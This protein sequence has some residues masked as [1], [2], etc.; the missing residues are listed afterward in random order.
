M[1]LKAMIVRVD[2]WTKRFSTVSALLA[3][4]FAI[5]LS[6]L[7]FGPSRVAVLFVACWI[8]EAMWIWFRG[9]E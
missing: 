9:E 8:G 4:S 1:Q 3:M 6:S 5:L 7:A 2:D